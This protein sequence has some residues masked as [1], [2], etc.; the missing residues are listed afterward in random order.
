MSKSMGL[1]LA[2]VMLCAGCRS[3]LPPRSSISD[4]ADLAPPLQEEA[5]GG[6]QLPLQLTKLTES[7]RNVSSKDGPSPQRFPEG[8]WTRSLD[9]GCHADLVI[10]PQRFCL[11][12][13]LLEKNHVFLEGEYTKMQAG[14]LSGVITRQDIQAGPL[15]LQ[16][17]VSDAFDMWF[18]QD[19][20]DL[21]VVKYKGGGWD[22][23]GEDSFRGRYHPADPGVVK[24]VFKTEAKAE[25]PRE[26]L[27]DAEA[28]VAEVMERPEERLRVI[29]QETPWMSSRYEQRGDH[30]SLELGFKLWDKK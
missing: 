3:H 7:E 13:H 24:D 14:L 5:A 2:L 29:S 27:P 1:F 16:T 21:V 19:G 9:N 23:K 8:T 20:G 30:Q 11:F 15:S 26:R 22:E 6:S 18:V 12:L 17:S 10:G 25:A 4:S 28:P